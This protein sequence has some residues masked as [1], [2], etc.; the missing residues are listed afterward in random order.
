MFFTQGLR[1]SVSNLCGIQVNGKISLKL[2]RVRILFFV[3]V[4]ML[5]DTRKYK[6]YS[7]GKRIEG[8]ESAEQTFIYP[9]HPPYVT[10]NI[11]FV[12]SFSPERGIHNVF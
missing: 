7:G 12:K 8:G 2:I 9:I 1:N 5:P 6:L 3:W 10:V 11:P 4:T